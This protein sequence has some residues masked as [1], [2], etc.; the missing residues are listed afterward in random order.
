[1]AIVVRTSIDSA[2]KDDHDRL[3]QFVE[4][5]VVRQGSPPKGLM[6]HL[7]YPSGDGFL[8]VNVWSS[9]TMFQ[10]WWRDVMESALSE[11]GLTASEHQ[12]DPVWSLA[13]P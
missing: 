7:S 4:A 5:G 2:D 11:A 12:I 1:M 3:D 8:I 13:R 6:V 10:S 9:E